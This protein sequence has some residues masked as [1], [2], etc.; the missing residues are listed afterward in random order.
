M[1]V[2]RV[3]VLDASARQ[4]LAACRALGHARYEVGAAGYS[5]AELAGYSRYTARYHQLPNPSGSERV[6]MGALESVV[7]EFGYSALVATDDATLARLNSSRPSIPTMPA[8]G[9]PFTSLTNK[10]HLAELAGRQG[11]DYPE[12]YPIDNVEQVETAL[13]L[14]GLPAVVKAERSAVARPAAVGWHS[15]VRIAYDAA[16]AREAVAMLAAKG[17]RP[18]V[19]RRV[20]WSS[21]TNVVIIRRGGRSELRYAHRV[22]REV[23][24]HGG[25]G[26]AMETMAPDEGDAAL[27][28][29]AL[30]RICDGAGYNGLAQ[31]ELYIGDGQ[32]WLID[33]NPR[34]WGSTWFAERLGLRVTER[35]LRA[36]LDEP[37]LPDAAYDVGRRFHH[38]PHE[39]RWI[40]R[41][42]P[43]RRSLLEV[44]RG[45]R[46]GDLFEY[47][48]WSDLGALTRYA[49]HKA[50]FATS[51]A[52]RAT[53]HQR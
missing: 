42:P 29:Q 37:P 52:L 21:K 3:L 51:R 49:G 39:L 47:V 34:L 27:S 6:F 44:A 43:I 12:T 28:L 35:A 33:V 30:E 41:Q 23:P 25:M 17:L 18:I 19:Q 13:E 26:V 24:P 11:V 14:T 40:K 22:L 36:A 32:A 53:N 15:G 7:A 38:L 1:S 16:S 8:L 46:P 31:A 4:A 20:R 50:A 2:S 45:M 5:R 10:L 9:E 48:D